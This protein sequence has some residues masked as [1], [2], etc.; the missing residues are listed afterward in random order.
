M[1]CLNA[2]LR[3]KTQKFTNQIF[4]CIKTSHFISTLER[5]NIQHLILDTEGMVLVKVSQVVGQVCLMC[6]V[7]AQLVQS[8]QT[9]WQ[10][11]I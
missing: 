2:L 10:S 4:L 3:H 6:P 1:P 8:D 7:P 9:Q 11:L 5:I